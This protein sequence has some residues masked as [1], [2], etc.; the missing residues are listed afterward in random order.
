MNKQKTAATNAGAG[1]NKH[2]EKL[3]YIT[4]NA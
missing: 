2:S 4:L 3:N 1:E